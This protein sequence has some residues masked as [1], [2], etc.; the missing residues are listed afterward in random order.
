MPKPADVIPLEPPVLVGAGTVGLVL[1][2]V[3]VVVLAVRVGGDPAAAVVLVIDLVVDEPA[4]TAVVTV[5]L[6][7]TTLLL[8]SVTGE[9]IMTSMLYTAVEVSIVAPE[10]FIVIVSILMAAVILL[11]FVGFTVSMLVNSVIVSIVGERSSSSK[12]DPDMSMY[13]I[14]ALY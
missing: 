8:I 3:V 4:M 6:A 13:S 11:V 14:L 5:G 7:Y 10:L 1:V 2:G 12:P 9:V